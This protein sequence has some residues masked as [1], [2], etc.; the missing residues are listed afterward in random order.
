MEH[1]ACWTIPQ[2]VSYVKFRK[3]S[4]ILDFNSCVYFFNTYIEL[5]SIIFFCSE[6]NLLALSCT[7]DYGIRPLILCLYYWFFSNLHA[8]FYVYACYFF[9]LWSIWESEEKDVLPVENVF[10]ALYKNLNNL[11]SSR[12]SGKK[13]FLGNFYFYLHE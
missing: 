2:Y 5:L 8:W 12:V 3:M 11:H 1:P 13:K 10:Y 9:L 4:C 7:E 6:K